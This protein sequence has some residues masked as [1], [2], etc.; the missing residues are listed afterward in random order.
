MASEISEALEEMDVLI[1]ITDEKNKLGPGD[2]YIIDKIKDLNLPK[3]ALINKSDIYKDNLS[4]EEEI[5]EFK[6]FDQVTRIAAVTGQNIEAAMSFV[7]AQLKEGPQ[8]FPTDYITDRP[9]WFVISELIREKALHLLEDELPH[10]VGVAIEKIEKRDN[11]ELIDVYAVIMCEKKSHKGMIIGKNGAKLHEIGKRARTDIE[12]LL[13]SQVY[14]NLW[15]KISP[16]WRDNEKM[17]KELGY[18]N[19]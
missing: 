5:R 11:K 19:W 9:E 18:K 4:V 7:K 17:L 10:G 2:K 15:V 8:Y 1:F 16:N 12:R 3:I 14:L 13:G 6:I